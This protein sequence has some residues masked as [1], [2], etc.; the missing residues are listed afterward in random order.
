[1][2]IFYKK[3][4]LLLF[5][6]MLLSILNCFNYA[7]A[8][9][10]NV[11]ITTV[12]QKDV[13]TRLSSLYKKDAYTLS[14]T[15]AKN[16]NYLLN[17]DRKLL[18]HAIAEYA[19]SSKASES[20]A[21]DFFSKYLMKNFILF[22][23]ETEPQILSTSPKS[24][25]AY[26]I[27][28]S[29]ANAD[30]LPLLGKEIEVNKNFIVRNTIIDLFRDKYGK[31]AIDSI[32]KIIPTEPNAGVRSKA[33]SLAFDLGD[34]YTDLIPL[35][36]K[37]YIK[38]GGTTAKNVY[39]NLLSMFSN[40]QRKTN[41]VEY[42]IS[43]LDDPSAAKLW[44]D[45]QLNSYDFQYYQLFDRFKNDPT[46]FKRLEEMDPKNAEIWKKAHDSYSVSPS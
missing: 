16:L 34:K 28:V 27:I 14:K 39:I 5:V 26:R 43:N 23:N 7:S 36:C 20:S 13:N 10:V 17:L 30:Q 19:S 15:D 45:M 8:L 32:T 18:L 38:V 1:M 9:S 46:V 35:I 44:K 31:A 25:A 29:V 11:G 42:L 41:W 37:P 12:F 2:R 6:S 21:I 40:E 22:L 4:I 33:I 3:I 24:E